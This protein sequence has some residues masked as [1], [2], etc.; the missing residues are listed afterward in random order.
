MRV[1]DRYIALK[2]L[3]ALL[4]SLLVFIAIYVI[5]DLV[6]HLDTFVDAQATTGQVVRYYLNFIPA[7]VVLTLPIAVLMATLFTVGGLSKSNELL[8]M[9]SSG[10]SLWR[11]GL[12][13]LGWGLAL[14]LLLLV[15]SEM[16]VPRTEQ[17]RSDI[18]NLEIEKKQ[19]DR[20]TI[21]YHVYVQGQDHRM[22]RLERYDI[23]Q[24]RGW[25]VLVQAIEDARVLWTIRANEMQW[26]DSMWVLRNGEERT[27]A[28][29]E[30]IPF[31]SLAR[32]DWKETPG[33][34]S[35]RD[36]SP[37]NMG[38]RELSEYIQVVERSG[39]DASRERFRLQF[40]LALP[41]MCFIIVMVGVPIASSPKRSGVALSFG[42]AS[43]IAIVY[44]FL[45]RVMESLGN[46]GDLP[47]MLAAWSMNGVFLLVG[48]GLFLA[49]RK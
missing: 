13:L 33:D 43:G 9:R 39:R 22:F 7:I 25:G 23:E 45:L 19:S 44:I 4:F 38:Y 10:L 26:V 17:E 3:R 24:R 48:L 27:F 46:K 11:I 20:R 14:S 36:R 16:V 35:Q 1:L 41:F 47:P 42:I 49:A 18:L 12:P 5:V 31:D 40:K 37:E 28:S 30:W 29:E 21:A 32:P 8:A 15:F 2:F 6:E 34:L